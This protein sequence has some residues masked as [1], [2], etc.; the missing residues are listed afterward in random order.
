MVIIVCSD[1]DQ[2]ACYLFQ[3]IEEVREGIKEAEVDFEADVARISSATD[4]STP[5]SLHR[6]L[7]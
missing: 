4:D 2:C 6:K 7:M 3:Q 5:L 1:R